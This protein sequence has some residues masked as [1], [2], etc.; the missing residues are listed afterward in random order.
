MTMRK[1]FIPFRRLAVI[2]TI[3]I[4]GL[5]IA[6]AATPAARAFD[7]TSAAGLWQKIEDG[8]S[9]GWFLVIEQ[10]GAYEGIIAKMFMKPGED[11]NIVF[12]H[13][14][15]QTMGASVFVCARGGTVVTCAATSG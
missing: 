4:T 13:P 8:K 3:A 14:G 1:T 5:A 12:E 9:V 7:P 10:N 2:A 6:F 11:P 15:R